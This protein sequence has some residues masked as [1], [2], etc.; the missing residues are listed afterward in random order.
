MRAVRRA[1][2]A[3]RGGSGSV[4]AAVR[5]LQIIAL[6]QFSANVQVALAG[7]G[8]GADTISEENKFIESGRGVYEAVRAVRK[9]VVAMR[10]GSGSDIEEEEED[11]GGMESREDSLL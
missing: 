6:P 8:A 7:L 1:V 2:V 3:M 4:V 11:C 9:A 5:E 10:G